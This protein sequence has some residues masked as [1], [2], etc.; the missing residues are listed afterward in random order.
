MAFLGRSQLL[1]ALLAAILAMGHPVAVHALTN[2]A[3]SRSEPIVGN[4]T[5]YREGDFPAELRR[6]LQKM[7]ALEL[8][9]PANL[10][11]SGY[12][13]PPFEADLVDS[14]NSSS[15][16]VAHQ[17][18]RAAVPA[19]FKVAPLS[20][21]MSWWAW[22]LLALGVCI[23]FT[24]FTWYVSCG[25]CG[26]IR[27]EATSG[28]DSSPT[29][30]KLRAKASECM[31]RT[32]DG[33]SA[34]SK[35]VQLFCAPAAGQW[36]NLLSNVVKASVD[37]FDRS[38]LGVDISIGELRVDACAGLV[39]IKHLTI[40]NPVGYRS[41]HFFRSEKIAISINMGRY[42]L[43]LGKR[44][45]VMTAVLR[46]TEVIYE[47]TWLSSNIDQVLKLLADRELARQTE[48][49]RDSRP[50]ESAA[51]GADA[52]P[53]APTPGCKGEA[54]DVKADGVCK[55]ERVHNVT[56]R[57]VMVENI[58]V[59]LAASLFRDMGAAVSAGDLHFGDLSEELGSGWNILD[60]VAFLLQNILRTVILSA[61]KGG[62]VPAPGNTEYTL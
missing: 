32:T 45:E 52:L 43:S 61:G 30:I 7:Q 10:L 21:D 60:A 33:T 34:P 24:A 57:K 22:V 13:I 5:E 29:G 46:G 17:Q 47:K 9:Q 59:K 8:S 28:K 2:R 3:V 42:I 48:R 41:K 35:T 4:V 58:G 62:P 37:R 16:P 31:H 11:G 38:F 56:V 14:S 55:G 27:T 26:S 19:M 18:K 53:A 23:S 49:E 6:Q 39:E 15:A 36:G 25:A 12:L 40:G 54:S 51:L 20:V 50:S 44:I 1:R